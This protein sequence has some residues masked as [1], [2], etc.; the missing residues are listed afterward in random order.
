MLENIHEA[1]LLQPIIAYVESR[2]ILTYRPVATMC[3]LLTIT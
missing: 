3:S 2:D 1:N